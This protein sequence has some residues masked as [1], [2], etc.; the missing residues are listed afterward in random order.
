MKPKHFAPDADP[1]EVTA[2]LGDHGFAIV[3][4]LADPGLLDPVGGRPVPTSTHRPPVRDVYD[5]RFTR[6]TGALIARCPAVRELVMNPLVV[7]ITE[8]F[9][10][11][12]QPRSSST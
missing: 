6:R 4:D 9:P 3:D 1:A 10:P 8:R 2:Y 7:A 12:G 5:G 11:S